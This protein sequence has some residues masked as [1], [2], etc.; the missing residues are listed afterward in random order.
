MECDT[1]APFLSRAAPRQ[2]YLPCTPILI[3]TCTRSSFILHHTRANIHLHPLL[4]EK[5]RLCAIDF[6]VTVEVPGIGNYHSALKDE[7]AVIPVVRG[8]EMR[9]KGVHRSP[10]QCLL[11]HVDGEGLK[12]LEYV[13][14][15]WLSRDSE[16]TNTLRWELCQTS[17]TQKAVRPGPCIQMEPHNSSILVFVALPPLLSACTN[18]GPGLREGGTAFC[19]LLRKPS[20]TWDNLSDLHEV[21]GTP[22]SSSSSYNLPENPLTAGECPYVAGQVC[23]D[24]D[25]LGRGR[26]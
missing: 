15:Q 6:G 4:T 13:F 10:L 5:S 7:H 24:R 23:S 3:R 17:K 26:R 12:K 14:A 20:R 9:G 25:D 8:R 18:R 2:W 16:G 11:D 22:Q 19:L 1:V 21:L